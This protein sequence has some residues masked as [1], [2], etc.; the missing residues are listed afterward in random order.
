MDYLLCHNIIGNHAK[1]FG[2][3]KPPTSLILLRKQCLKGCIIF[4]VIALFALLS[5]GVAFVIPES[6]IW[7]GFA[8]LVAAMSLVA[9]YHVR[10]RY[11]LAGHLLSAKIAIYWSQPRPLNS[12][13]TKR[14]L[15]GK[16][17]LR[18]HFDNGE[19]LDID[20]ISEEMKYFRE[21]VNQSH[22]DVYWTDLYNPAMLGAT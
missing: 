14:A 6:K 12:N 18:L 8:F 15:S 2:E 11:E 16:Q 13:L 19:H 20:V 10:S 9:L 21:W 17:S 4:K 3:M 22:P 7:I 5:G 1:L